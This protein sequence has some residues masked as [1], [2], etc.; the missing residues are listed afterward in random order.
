ME[1]AGKT[2]AFILTDSIYDPVRTRIVH[3]HR[4]NTPCTASV[5]TQILTEDIT[6][7]L[8]VHWKQHLPKQDNRS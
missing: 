6:T 5:L 7:T 2:K 8:F 4:G 3:C 1:A